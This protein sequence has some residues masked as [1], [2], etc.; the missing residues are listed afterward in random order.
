MIQNNCN[1]SA[2]AVYGRYSKHAEQ[3]IYGIISMPIE[4]ESYTVR[5]QRSRRGSSLIDVMLSLFLLS[6]V[7]VIFSATFPPAISCSKQALYYKTA[8]ALAEQKMEEIRGIDY[9]SL[10]RPLLVGRGIIDS[11]S[12]ESAFFFTQVDNVADKLPQGAGVLQITEIPGDLKR[13][14]IT[15]SWEGVGPTGRRSI[16]LRSLVADKRTRAAG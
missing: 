8:N 16:T 13:I 15:V 9:E 1:T 12:S 4:Q 10:T 2:R 11:S 7:G 14:T 6:I 3:Q 5:I